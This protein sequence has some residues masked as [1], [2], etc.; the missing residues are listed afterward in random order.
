M[1]ACGGQRNDAVCA[2]Y[3]SGCQL[4]AFAARAGPAASESSVSPDSLERRSFGAPRQVIGADRTRNPL[5]GTR[6]TRHRPVQP[7]R[8]KHTPALPH[9]RD[10]GVLTRSP[11]HRVPQNPRRRRVQQ[12]R[13]HGRRGGR[14]PRPRATSNLRSC[15][16]QAV[17]SS[18][19][20]DTTAPD[21]RHQWCDGD[22]R[23]LLHPGEQA[24]ARSSTV[25]SELVP[26]DTVV[27]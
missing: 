11:L 15:L 13:D 10:I 20:V 18:G 5:G 12:H 21:D 3:S 8:G 26:N 23:L 27:A 16:P 1:S 25:R 7:T 22:D 4:V 24:S 9:R 2:S 17:V 14:T 19:A 6:G